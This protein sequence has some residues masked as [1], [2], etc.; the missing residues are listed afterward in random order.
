MK[1]IIA[2][3]VAVRL[4][5]EHDEVWAKEQYNDADVEARQELES[6]LID[7]LHENDPCLRLSIYV[8]EAYELKE[9][10]DRERRGWKHDQYDNVSHDQNGFND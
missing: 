2:V 9:A 3:L 1:V 10:Y 5:D 4:L 7:D 8:Q 6:M